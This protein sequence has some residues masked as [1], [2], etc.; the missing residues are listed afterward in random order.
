MWE[1]DGDLNA[2]VAV[3]DIVAKDLRGVIRS[4]GK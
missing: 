3:A 1:W 2:V 4:Q